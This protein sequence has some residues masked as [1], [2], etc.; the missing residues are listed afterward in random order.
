MIKSLEGIVIRQTKI[1]GGRRMILLFSKEEGKI[2]AGT[3]ISE[4][5]K[6]NS[7]LAL[8]PFVHGLYQVTEKRKDQRNI[9]SAETI[10]PHFALGEDIDRYAEAAYVLEF[11][12]KLLPEGVSEPDI[13]ELLKDYLDIIVRRKDDF[14][15]LTISY[16]VKVMQVL[17]VFPDA[18]SLKGDAVSL[19]GDADSRKRG[20]VSLKD[21]ADP[22]KENAV[23]LKDGELLSGLNDDILDVLVFIEEQPLKRMETL[24]LESEK[25]TAVFGLMKNFAQK[26][27]DLGILKSER[28]F[29]QGSA[30]L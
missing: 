5:S 20:A 12:D 9:S 25:E 23:F 15:L 16:M 18:D 8:R 7:A 26:H 24:T 4:K 2:S 28:L 11:T 21:N 6:G 10:N 1:T 17:G 30:K 27:L 3:H 29:A 14:R 13:F 22:L 19:K